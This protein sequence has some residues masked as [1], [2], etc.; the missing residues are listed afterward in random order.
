MYALFLQPLR[1]AILQ[2]VATTARRASPGPWVSTAL[3]LAVGGGSVIAGAMPG[4]AQSSLAGLADCAPPQPGE[5]L[6]LVVVP[7]EG[8][9]AKLD[10]SLPPS[11][12][13]PN[14]NYLGSPVAR[15][16]GF[17]QPENADAWATYLRDVAS[18]R[19]FVA[20]P[21]A[22]AIAN[23]PSPQ[24]VQDPAAQAGP[25]AER[26]GL[27]L[28]APSGM[29][30]AN[31]GLPADIVFPPPMIDAQ[32]PLATPVDVP[33]VISSSAPVV[34]NVPVVLAPGADP[35][36]ALPAAAV[37]QPANA[38]GAVLPSAIA[39]S[40]RALGRGYA[41]LVDYGNQTAVVNQVRQV[42]QVPVGLATYGQ[43]PY[44]V[45]RFTPQGALAVETLTHLSRAGLRAILVEGNEVTLLTA[46][47]QGQ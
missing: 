32:P 15:M 37:G 2:L 27:T 35:S 39:F 26:N 41:V 46:E 4:R 13:A 36:A 5:Y 6:L 25:S 8:A 40:P 17:R 12:K 28:A 23:L 20:K 16:G 7:D 44:L 42:T 14:C 21:A 47:V 38:N 22:G 31:P 34:A 43:R 11:V 33:P 24:M 1:H 10:Q 3:L 29:V 9:R 45:A 30:G 18:L 19:A